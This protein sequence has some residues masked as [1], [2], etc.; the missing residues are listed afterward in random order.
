MPKF[1]DKTLQIRS[2]GYRILIFVLNM[3]IWCPKER[4]WRILSTFFVILKI[5]GPRIPIFEFAK[6]TEK[7][8]H[9]STLWKKHYVLQQLQTLQKTLRFLPLHFPNNYNSTNSTNQIQP[10]Q[11]DWLNIFQPNSTNWL[12]FVEFV[13]FNPKCLYSTISTKWCIWAGVVLRIIECFVG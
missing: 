13:E 3:R 5:Q 12:N 7:S 4:M 11:L 10:I 2:F 1:V 8:D 9:F 6:K